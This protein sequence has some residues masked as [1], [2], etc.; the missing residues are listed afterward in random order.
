MEHQTV[1]TASGQMIKVLCTRTMREFTLG[2]HT[3]AG[4]TR[5][6][7]GQPNGTWRFGSG[8]VV[9]RSNNSISMNIVSG[10]NDDL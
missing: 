4:G 9:L 6:C 2:T 3:H 1:A 5:S 7:T 8:A 10:R